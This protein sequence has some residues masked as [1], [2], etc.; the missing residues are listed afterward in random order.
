MH[1]LLKE[2]LRIETL[3][4]KWLDMLFDPGDIFEVRVKKQKEFGA[5]QYWFSTEHI[6]KFITQNLPIHEQNNRNVWIGVMART[7]A[8][9]S[10][11]KNGKV[12]WVDFSEAV[13]TIEQVTKEISE[14]SLPAPTMVVWSGNGY[15]AYWQLD[16]KYS[17]EEVKPYVKAI[18]SLLTADNTHDSTRVMRV[19]GTMNMKDPSSPKL[20][21]LEA[22]VPS[23]VYSLSTFPKVETS[24]VKE[25]PKGG[26]KLR[27]EERELF[28][29]NWITGQ[30]HDMTLAVAGYLRKDLGYTQEEAEYEI[31]SIHQEAG[32]EIPDAGI[33]QT[34]DSTYR[35]P[36]ERITGKGKLYDLD[37]RFSDITPQT[38][39]FRNKKPRI[40]MIDFSQDIPKQKFWIPGLVGP[41]LMTI[42]AAPP[43]TGKSFAIMQLGYALATGQQLWDFPKDD[44]DR[45]RVLYF[46]G[47]LSQNMVA[48]RAITLFG[49][50]AVSNPQQFALTDKPDELFS[51]I[52]NPEILTDMAEDYDVI[53]IDPISVFSDSDENSKNG[54]QQTLSVFDSLLAKKKSVIL[55]HHTRKLEERYDKAGN[56][57]SP[58]PTAN[59]I[60]GSGAWFARADAISLHYPFGDSGN[61]K[62]DFTF[63]AAPERPTLTLYR[64]PHGGFTNSLSDY[65][66]VSIPEDG[67][68]TLKFN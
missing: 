16:K 12:L 35:A 11:P 21:R 50:A 52:T 34:V 36:L 13:T 64:L 1:S 28:I 14:A 25:L 57:I 55:V 20:C 46:Q 19:P 17:P 15:H 65:K 47:E 4:R 42:W 10:V 48:E 8:G 29:K 23:L 49:K 43:K 3:T 56:K 26:R 33:S 30:R 32:H 60:R 18:H 38:V 66:Q 63:R 62:V 53:I 59:D 27:R 41:G 61:T 44:F 68:F 51:L 2:K 37:V 39:R 5:N 22:H 9:K 54:V 58:R 31:Q 67:K 6:E 40:R 24:T 45:Q 7:E